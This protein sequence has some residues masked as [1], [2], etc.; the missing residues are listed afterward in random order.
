[1]PAHRDIV[2][3]FEH[4]LAIAVPVLGDKPRL[5]RCRLVQRYR[6]LVEAAGGWLRVAGVAQVRL[7]GRCGSSGSPSRRSCADVAT[8]SPAHSQGHLT[9]PSSLCTCCPHSCSHQVTA[10][11]G[12]L[13]AAGV[14]SESERRGGGRPAAC[15]RAA[16]L[17]AR[18]QAHRC[19]VKR[20]SSMH[21]TPIA[22][23]SRQ[24]LTGSKAGP[25]RAGKELTQRRANAEQEIGLQRAGMQLAEPAGGRS[26]P[27]HGAPP[28]ERP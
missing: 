20:P 2:R 21:C 1:M 25:G 27:L 8:L 15:S 17:A 10:T 14:G 13:Q 7:A 24:E 9:S 16:P 18:L 22:L 6:L 26:G 19:A 12:S 23:S 11:T 5:Q 4:Q 3:H 28:D